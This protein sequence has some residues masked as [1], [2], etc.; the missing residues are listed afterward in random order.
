MQYNELVRGEAPVSRLGFGLMRLPTRE[1]NGRR[2][3]DRERAIGMIRHGIDAGVS[4]VDTAY[5]YHDG[6]SEIVAGLALKDGYRENY[7]TK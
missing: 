3:I 6:E 1:E 2:V 7:K 4:Y 5:M